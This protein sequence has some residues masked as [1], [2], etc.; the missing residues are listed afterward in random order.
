MPETDNK[1]DIKS[2]KKSTGLSP[3]EHARPVSNNIRRRRIVPGVDENKPDGYIPGWN[4]RNNP[5]NR[6]QYAVRIKTVG[7]E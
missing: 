2:Y 3:H 5:S 1:P 6:L 4:R 7:S